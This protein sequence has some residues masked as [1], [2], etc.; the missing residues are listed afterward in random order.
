MKKNRFY[1]YLV[2]IR[3]LYITSYKKGCENVIFLE[4]LKCI[5]KPQSSSTKVFL[6]YLFEK[7][8]KAS[9]DSSA[10]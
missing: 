8:I 1:Y 3:C 9:D 2:R 6:E 7:L 5:N 10:Y 4:I